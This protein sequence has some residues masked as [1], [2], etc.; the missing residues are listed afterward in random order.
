MIPI[1]KASLGKQPS[2][3]QGKRRRKH[4]SDIRVK[5]LRVGKGVTHQQGE[6][7]W[8]KEYLEVTI[9]T[10]GLNEVEVEQQ[11]KRMRL[12]LDVKLGIIDKP[13]TKSPDS[14]GEVPEAAQFNP[15]ELMQHEWKGKSNPRGGYYRG[16]LEFGWDFADK[17]SENVL[18]CLPLTISGYHFSL[19]DNKKL[20]QTKKAKP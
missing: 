12:Y 1:R 14:T 2:K 9:D 16:S 13:P 11:R 8:R 19:T 20:V 15:E 3:L 5:E 4:L 17:F 7:E 18:K 6:N 10:E